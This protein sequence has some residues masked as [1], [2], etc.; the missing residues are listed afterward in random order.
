MKREGGAP[1]RISEYKCD[2]RP[3]VVPMRGDRS[4]ILPMDMEVVAVAEV[5][6][7]T[8]FSAL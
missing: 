5:V 7:V 1:V 2:V 8:S 3:S 6:D 4:G